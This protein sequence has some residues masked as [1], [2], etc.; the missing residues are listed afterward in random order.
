MDMKNAI[1][2]LL[3]LLHIIV[4]VS[5]FY[6]IPLLT[7]NPDEGLL[8]SGAKRI[9]EGQIPYKDFFY[10]HTSGDA[11]LLALFFII[12]GKT[13][14]IAKSMVFFFTFLAG[15]TLGI[16]IFKFSKN[17]LLTGICTL[18]YF[19][20]IFLYFQVIHHLLSLHFVIFSMFTLTFSPFLAGIFSAITFLIHEPKGALCILFYAIF[21]F[22]KDN[23]M[24]AD[25]YINLFKKHKNLLL[26]LSGSALVMIIFLSAFILTNALSDYINAFIFML[27]HYHKFDKYPF[28]YSEIRTAKQSFFTGNISSVI[29][30]ILIFVSLFLIPFLISIILISKFVILKFVKKINLKED[31]LVLFALVIFVLFLSAFYRPDSIRIMFYSAPLSIPFILCVIYRSVLNRFKVFLAENKNVLR[32]LLPLIFI[33]CSSITLYRFNSM[34]SAK[35]CEIWT[36]KETVYSYSNSMCYI[37]KELRD[38]ISQGQDNTIFIYHYSP[39]IYFL[40]DKR[41]P[42]SYDSYKPIYNT[43]EQLNIIIEELKLNPPQYVIK[44]NYIE[45]VKNPHSPVYYFFPKVERLKLNYDP[46]DDF[47]K[48]NYLVEKNLGLFLILKR[49][50]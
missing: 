24:C 19:L 35:R 40:F 20:I 36:G 34:I 22:L 48:Q 50:L 7:G 26:F 29:F 8:L 45:M 12:F 11:Y 1:I 13:Y 31:P 23:N 25:I 5:Y 33:L 39:L 14:F 3:V 43:K 21:L 49:K 15:L 2:F 28:L 38:F 9:L 44:D 10:P 18:I 30:F 42:T 17:L 27:T 4:F 32:V 41:N 37:Y 47:I 16:F 46:V 6:N